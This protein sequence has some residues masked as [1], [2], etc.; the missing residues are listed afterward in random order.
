MASGFFALLQLGLNFEKHCPS[1]CLYF[2][3][4]TL[5]SSSGCL[6]NSNSL[7]LPKRDAQMTCV[8]I[9]GA[10][11]SWACSEN[12][13]TGRLQ[14]QRSKRLYLYRREEKD[15]IVGNAGGPRNWWSR[16]SGWGLGFHSL[17]SLPEGR[18]VSQV[19]TEVSWEGEVSSC[20]LNHLSF[21]G[22]S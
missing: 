13:C 7:Q 9:W 18:D 17:F 19:Q 14:Q 21:F 4:T 22:T 5:L 20:V 11:S 10:Q 12:E 8:E 16:G 6:S 3:I 15:C 2:F 1:N